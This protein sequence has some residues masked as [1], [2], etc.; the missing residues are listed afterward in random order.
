MESTA[1]VNVLDNFEFNI[2]DEEVDMSMEG[3][4]PPP[5]RYRPFARA[6]HIRREDLWN[7][8]WGIMLKDSNVDNIRT[9]V[10]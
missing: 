10:C 3:D 1:T 8:P 4:F 9:P 2:I 5:K 6:T 7:S